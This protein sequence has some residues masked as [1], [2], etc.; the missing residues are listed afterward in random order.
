MHRLG[1]DKVDG[2][3]G[4]HI[5]HK[6]SCGIYIK[7]STNYNKYVGFHSCA[8]R[9]LYHRHRLTEEHDERTEQRTVASLCSRLHD[10]IVLG[11]LNM[12][13]LI[14]RID[15]RAH[16]HQFAVQVDDLSRTGTLV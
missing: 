10:R 6:S 11:E 16:L 1:V 15:T 14:I 4:T 12:I 9:R 3:T 7:R 5:S 13:S 2:H 8:C